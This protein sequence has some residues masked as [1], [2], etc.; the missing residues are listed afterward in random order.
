MPRSSHELLI[1]DHDFA[2]DTISDV[3]Q[4]LDSELLAAGAG[5]VTGGGIGS[6]WYRIEMA[7]A[8]PADALEVIRRLAARLELPAS[9]LLRPIGADRALPLDAPDALGGKAQESGG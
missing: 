2:F 7:I 5:E 3:E 8:R 6:G 1:P 4:P 9:T